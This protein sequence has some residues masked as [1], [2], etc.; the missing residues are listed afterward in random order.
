MSKGIRR[1]RLLVY[2]ATCIVSGAVAALGWAGAIDSFQEMSPLPFVL[3]GIVGLLAG[4]VWMGRI[5][6][7]LE[8]PSEV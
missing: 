2:F 4:I 1:L 8:D 6:S 7:E 5:V 3:V